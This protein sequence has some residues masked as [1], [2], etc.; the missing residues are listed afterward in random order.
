MRFGFGVVEEAGGGDAFLAEAF[1][2]RNGH[3]AG[4]RPSGS[5]KKQDLV[6]FQQIEPNR[7]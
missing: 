6:G 3:R 5:A 4:F 1:G 7:S 2:Q